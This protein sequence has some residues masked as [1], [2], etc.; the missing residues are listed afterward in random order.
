MINFKQ[1]EYLA[2]SIMA[3]ISIVIMAGALIFML[4][5]PAPSV[6]RSSKGR[7]LSR[8]KLQAEIE[9]IRRQADESDKAIA[10]RIRQGDPE[11][12]TSQ[13]LKQLTADAARR[14]LKMTAF[15]PQRTQPLEGVTELPYS[16]H[17]TGAFPAVRAML[18]GLDDGHT[19][20]ALRSYQFA[21]SDESS[22][23]VTATINLSVYTPSATQPAQPA[24]AANSD[25]GAKSD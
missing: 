13:V 15:R 11:A 10:P 12:I 5:V 7:E 21:S 8:R 25:S 6:A 22:S 23:A 24:Q 3:L 20:L 4:V 14:G 9:G 16:A 1:R 18:T 19:K 17:V 2:P